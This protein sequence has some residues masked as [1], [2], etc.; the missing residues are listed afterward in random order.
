LHEYKVIVS[1]KFYKFIITN[2]FIKYLFTA[3]EKIKSTY[4]K[5]KVITESNYEATQISTA[6]R[7]DFIEIK[8][9]NP[10][11]NE[12]KSQT[13]IVHQEMINQQSVHRYIN[14]MKIQTPTP[15][16]ANSKIPNVPNKIVEY[17]IP[18]V[19]DID[20]DKISVNPG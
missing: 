20:E 3:S 18:I 9:E 8:A 2:Y 7:K 14:Q 15:L 4:A 5:P 10:Y 13:P 11:L 1:K 17:Y 6:P 19:Q 12:F 16:Q